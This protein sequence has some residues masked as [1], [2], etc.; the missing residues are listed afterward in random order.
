MYERKPY[1]KKESVKPKS[2]NRHPRRRMNNRSNDF[3]YSKTKKIENRVPKMQK[4]AVRVLIIGGV[5]EIGKNMYAVEYND[6]IIILNCGTTKLYILTL[7]LR[8]SSVFNCFNLGYSVCLSFIIAKVNSREYIVG[9][10]SCSMT[11][12][13]PPMWSR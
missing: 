13:M 1:K 9:Y 5:G 11:K 2:N 8:I 7:F 12:G 10:P 6:D 4:D 3:S